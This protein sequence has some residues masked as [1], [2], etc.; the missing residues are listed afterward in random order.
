MLIGGSKWGAISFIIGV[1]IS[2]IISGIILVERSDMRHKLL[3]KISYLKIEKERLIS[4]Q[5]ELSAHKEKIM[6]DSINNSINQHHKRVE[7]LKVQKEEMQKSLMKE[8][9]EKIKVVVDQLV[10]L[11]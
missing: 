4:E 9:E 10:P 11:S 5:K 6:F 2:T 7:E 1:I 8:A 3:R